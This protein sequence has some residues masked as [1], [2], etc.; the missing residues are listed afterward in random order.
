MANNPPNSTNLADII[1]SRTVSTIDDV[2]AVMRGIDA[3]LP[4]GDGLKWFNLLYL[5]VTE[6]VLGRPPAEGWKDP[7]WLERL[8]V[9]FAGLYLAAVAAW[10]Q[11]PDKVARCWFPLLASRQRSN[12]KRLQFALAGMNAHINHDLPIAVVQTAK[13]RGIAP[14]RGSPQYRDF[15]RVNAIL[16]IV[17]GEV[18]RHIATGIIDEIDQK[19]GDID[20]ILAMWKVRKARETAW[21]NAEIIWRLESAPS[22]TADDDFLLNLDRLVGLASRGFLVATG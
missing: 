20:D 7:A 22:A 10:E 16:E 14:R 18:K 17:E 12:I 8:D 19:L 5:K 6:G 4:N 2:L 11:N 15:D 1:A 21:L 3:A 13:E 9:V